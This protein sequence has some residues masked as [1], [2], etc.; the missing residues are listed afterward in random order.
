MSEPSIH[1]DIINNLNYKNSILEAESKFIS[2]DSLSN[3][4]FSANTYSNESIL[5]TIDYKHLKDFKN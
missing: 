3:K 5:D 1:S 4:N 2:P